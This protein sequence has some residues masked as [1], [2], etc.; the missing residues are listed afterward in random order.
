MEHQSKE[1]L[2][3]KDAVSTNNMPFLKHG[4]KDKGHVMMASHDEMETE[5][6]EGQLPEGEPDLDHMS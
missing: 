6:D 2:F 5:K 3:Q 4:D 1:I